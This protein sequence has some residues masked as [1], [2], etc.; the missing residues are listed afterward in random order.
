MSVISIFTV[1]V[2]IALAIAVLAV[3]AVL[4]ITVVITGGM[5]VHIDTVDDYSYIVQL[6]FVDQ[7]VDKL[8]VALRSETGT[9]YIY[10]DVGYS[11]DELGICYHADRGAVDYY[12]VE[13]LL[14]YIYGIVQ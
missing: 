5:A 10:C 12:I 7:L 2:A 4:A 14:Q 1:T 11:G 6:A 3:A 13:V 8:E 9:A